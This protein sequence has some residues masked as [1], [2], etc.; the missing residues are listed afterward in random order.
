[1]DTNLNDVDWTANRRS[2]SADDPQFEI[3][4]R[5]YYTDKMHFWLHEPLTRAEKRELSG[6]CGGR[7]KIPRPEKTLMGGWLKSYH[8]QQPTNA[9]LKWLSRYGR[10]KLMINQ[11]ELAF[12]FIL[13]TQ[14]EADRLRDYLGKHL[15]QPW[16]G[17]QRTSRVHG[18][19][20]NSGGGWVRNS[21]AIYDSLPS[22][23]TGEVNCCHLEWRTNTAD[24]VRKLGI[25]EAKDL[26]DFDH[27]GFWQKKAKLYDAPTERLGRYWLN[28]QTGSYR[29]HGW[30]QKRPPG[31]TTNMDL[32]VGHLLKTAILRGNDF[33]PVRPL[34]AVQDLVD[35]YGII[36]RKALVPLPSDWLFSNGQKEDLV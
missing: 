34:G 25:G 31:I 32:R 29:Q 3:I 35:A 4:G 10:D 27:D 36:A 16:H 18:T 23:V 20:Y 9:A 2:P 26:I 1:M 21:Y 5:Y 33:S 28:R 8:I 24:A 30:K 17:R 13:R 22:K 19:Y 11:V 6:L 7:L 15:L 14:E 12:D